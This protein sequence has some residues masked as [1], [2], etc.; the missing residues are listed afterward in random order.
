MEVFD[1][2]VLASISSYGALGACCIYF[3]WKD[4][5][6]NKKLT[7]VLSDFTVAIKVLNNQVGVGSDV[8]VKL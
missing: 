1:T 5:T 3:M 4:C 2:N 8:S 7:E 6:V